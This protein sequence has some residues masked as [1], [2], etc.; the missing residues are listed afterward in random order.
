MVVD[1]FLRE[2]TEWHGQNWSEV[3]WVD[4]ASGWS[5]EFRMVPGFRCVVE[6]TS[7]SVTFRSTNVAPLEDAFA[8]ENLNLPHYHVGCVL[9]RNGRVVSLEFMGC[10]KIRRVCI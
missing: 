8:I 7:P 3:R 10:R 9:E 1:V 2:G 4:Q 5:W 6:I